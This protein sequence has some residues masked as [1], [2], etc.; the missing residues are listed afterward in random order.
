MP[1]IRRVGGSVI[2][3]ID[4]RYVRNN[5]L[6][7][8]DVIVAFDGN[9]IR[10]NCHGGELIATLSGN[11]IRS[12]FTGNV[13]AEIQGE[14]IR[15]PFSGQLLYIVEGHASQIEKASLAIGAMVLDNYGI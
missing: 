5:S 13:I 9:D 8:N 6:W 7:G 12:S 2:A 3:V 15:N 11:E 10:R 1:E 14:E 4:N